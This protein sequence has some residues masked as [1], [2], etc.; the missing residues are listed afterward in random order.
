MVLC[1]SLL[2]AYQVFGHLKTDIAEPR[3]G[4]A[5]PA[6]HGT[7]HLDSLCR[8]REHEAAKL[9]RDV[10]RAPANV[11]PST[12]SYLQGKASAPASVQYK[13]QKSA[14]EWTLGNSLPFSLLVD[15]TTELQK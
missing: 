3:S 10:R 11:A 9:G 15:L 13:T 8:A 5:C 4:T 7:E 12:L 1:R 6:K 2:F 14:S